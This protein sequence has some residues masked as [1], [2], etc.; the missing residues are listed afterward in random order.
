[1]YQRKQD[2]HEEAGKL[3]GYLEC[4]TRTR[5]T[6][7]SVAKRGLAMPLVAPFGG[8]GKTPWGIHF[9]RIFQL[10]GRSLEDVR[11]Q[12]LLL[13]P[14]S[15]GGWMERSVTAEEGGEWL[16][17]MLTRRLH[18]CDR[19]TIHTLKGAPLSWCGEFGLSPESRLLL[20]RHSSGKHLADTYA[21]DVLAQPLPEYEEVLRQI[22]AGAF[23]PD[24]TRSG[25]IGAA[26]QEDPKEAASEKVIE[27]AQEEPDNESSESSSAT[28]E[29]EASIDVHLEEQEAA[30]QDLVA[31]P[32]QWEPDV[33]MYLHSRSSIVHVMA[34]GT[35]NNRF[36]CGNVLTKDYRLVRE[37]SF[38]ELRKCKRCALARP[39]R[40]VGAFASALKKRRLEG[41]S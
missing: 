21:R 6:A 38:L 40:N 7:R 25:L 14:D 23:R 36:S 24:N 11:N 32:T 8:T 4:K 12:P 18:L 41:K 10:S 16:V 27:R 20:G 17:S 37:V 1:M 2:V 9:S 29:S 28:S 33:N 3:S 13:A 26:V 35:S 39:V 5:K 15:E 31:Q 19:I 22:R 34:C 30:S